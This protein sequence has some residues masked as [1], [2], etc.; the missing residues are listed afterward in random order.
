MT[1]NAFDDDVQA[2]LIAG[3]NA[4]LTKPIDPDVLLACMA[5]QIA[6]YRKK[7]GRSHA[8]NTKA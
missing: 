7:H 3:M 2:S 4:H 6:Q 5:E 8:D 1:A